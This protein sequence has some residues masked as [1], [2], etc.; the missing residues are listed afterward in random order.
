MEHQGCQ[1][2]L[3][4]L[5]GYIDQD[6]SQDLCAEIERHLAGCDNCRIVVDTLRKTVDLYHQSVPQ[7]EMPQDVRERLFHRLNLDEFVKK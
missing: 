6:I 5:S 1:H 3:N 4:S 7:P 2:L